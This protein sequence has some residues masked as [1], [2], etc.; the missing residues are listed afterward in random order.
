ML[1]TTT[2]ALA[3]MIALP[4]ANATPHTPAKGKTV[5]VTKTQ[6]KPARTVVVKKPARTVIVKHGPNRV[7]VPVRRAQKTVI[8]KTNARYSAKRRINRQNSR[9][10]HTLDLIEDVID[11]AV[12]NGPRDRRE[13]RI[14][15]LNIRPGERR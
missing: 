12:D 5:I 1:K 9:T 4:L 7:A 10:R 2:L 15:A 13:D 3:A 14:D 11:L 6:A 8:V